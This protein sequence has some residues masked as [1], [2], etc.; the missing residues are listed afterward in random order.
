MH[1]AEKGEGPLVLFLHGFPKL[2]YTWHHQIVYLADHGYR[3]VAPDLRG[4]GQTTGAPLNDHTKFTIHY[5]VGNLLGSLTPS[6]TKVKRF[7]LWVMTGVR[8]SLG[9][10]ACFGPIESKLWST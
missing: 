5:V 1:I 10:C 7:S 2:W 6:Q 8:S 4:Y 9:S 3:A